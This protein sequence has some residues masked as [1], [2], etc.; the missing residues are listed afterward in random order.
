MKETYQCPPG[1]FDH[2][3]FKTPPDATKPYPKQAPRTSGEQERGERSPN[4]LG[5][6]HH[7]RTGWG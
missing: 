6:L 5:G 1:G 2:P 3:P 4:R 7:C